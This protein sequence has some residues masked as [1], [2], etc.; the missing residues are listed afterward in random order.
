MDLK[1]SDEQQMIRAE[2]SRY[3]DEHAS[4]EAVRAVVDGGGLWDEVLWTGLARDMGMAGIAIP[5]AYGGLGLG[6]T[7]LT[8]LLA[9]I[10]KRLAPVPYYSTVGLAA[11]VL[12]RMGTTEARAALLPGIAAGETKA[13]VAFPALG[14]A[15]PLAGPSVRAVRDGDGYRL[16]GVVEQVPDL[17][18]ADLVLV[19]AL[20]DGG[21]VA[22]FAL[23]PGDGYGATPLKSL[24]AT[25]PIGRLVLDSVFVGAPSRIDDAAGS[26]RDA[27]P[28]AMLA[29][30]AEQAGAAEACFDLTLAYISER[31]QFGRTIASFQA[32]KH[33]CAD[34]WVRIGIVRS[35]VLGTAALSDSGAS[36]EV[37]A[38]E[39]AAA[40]A[41][42]SETLFR[43]AAEA[44]QMHGGV[45]FTWDYDPHFYLKRAQ[46]SAHW[47]GPPQ[48]HYAAIGS[49]LLEG[50]PVAVAAGSDDDNF[51]K[52]V[53]AW[54]ADR[55]TGAF[56]PLRFRG[57]AGDGEALPELRK[58]WERELATGGWVGLGWPKSAGGRDL[59]VADQVTFQ[60]EY[61]RAGGPGRIGHVGE[62]LIGPTIIAFG[63]EE[64]KARHLPGILGGTTFWGQGY[65][66]PGAGSDLANVR[67]R[68]RQDPATGDWL[69]SGQ[70]T[71]TS[72]AHLSDWIFVL[73]RSEEG[74][75]GRNG[76]IFLLLPLRQDGI[77]IHPIRQINGGAEFNSVFF[78]DARA[79]AT[80][81]VGKPGEGWKIAMALL[82]FERGISTLG[83]QMGFAGELEMI[84]GLAR[85]NGAGND[86]MIRQR[87]GRAWAGLRA[88]RYGALR[89]LGGLGD[90]TAGRESL[91]YKYE[92]SNW[93][94]ELGELGM[95]VLG[96]AGNIVDGTPETTRLQNL[97]LFSRAETIYGGSNEIQL[98][99]I[100]E[101]G[102]G[103][104]REP[105]GSLG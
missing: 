95:D 49:R 69:V 84:V 14:D 12:M 50:E 99:I 104:P 70:K 35:M 62:G 28:L 74:S 86:P 21:A 93:H 77:T 57:G 47:F 73:A 82:G 8:L 58:R 15:D 36:G 19:P 22:L 44:I 1:L 37:V 100:A 88:M 96:A 81:V 20:S 18:L 103:M 60:E 52:T 98:N 105:R 101:R 87:L 11:P 16:D 5:E 90:G 67:T 7:E 85:R 3:L 94:R 4:R 65:S 97:F 42:A 80:D 41:M 40:H 102:L 6:M 30:A 13:T 38:L 29:L 46:A 45:G 51:R 17:P 23:T 92:W 89:V 24:D 66:E 55:L 39:A 64:Q 48:A 78:D 33:R 26:L 10:G 31:V 79:L 2:A 9:E 53:A 34:L 75:V 76:L 91:G 72:L 63:T 56:E 61:A 54:M 43:V 83:Q 68:A 71:W 25:R 32:I 59:S 27:L